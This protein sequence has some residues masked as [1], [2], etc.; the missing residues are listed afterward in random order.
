[1]L[2][3]ITTE[4]GDSGKGNGKEKAPRNGGA[5]VDREKI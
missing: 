4:R 1:L 2:S 3:D 5:E